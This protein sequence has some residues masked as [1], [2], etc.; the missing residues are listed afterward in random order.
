MLLWY[1]FRTNG[2]N[3]VSTL[4]LVK[5]HTCVLILFQVEHFEDV[6]DLRTFSFPTTQN[7]ATSWASQ[8]AVPRDVS[9]GSNLILRA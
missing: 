8:K 5:R 7:L 4:M 3:P 1:A 2:R 6:P 9:T